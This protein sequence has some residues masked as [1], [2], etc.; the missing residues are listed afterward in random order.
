M[1]FRVSCPGTSR[2]YTIERRGDLREDDARATAFA[3]SPRRSRRS[4]RSRASSCSRPARATRRPSRRASRTSPSTCS[5]RARS[6]DRRR[7]RSRPRSTRSAAS[8]TRSRARSSPATT[9]AAARRHA[10][11]RSTSSPTCSS[12]R[13]STRRR[14]TK[15]KG[16]I[17]EEM[18]VYLDTP[19]R[20]VGNVYDRLL[21]ADQPLGW[22]ILGT[23]ETIEEATR[24]TFTSYLDTWYRPERMVVGI[25]G[26][27]GDGLTERLEE[28]LGWHRGPRDR[29]ARGR[30][31]PA[32]LLAG[33]AAHEGLGA[34][35]PHSRRARLP[36]R[37]SEPVRAPAARGRA[38]RRDVVAPLHRGAREARPRLLRA[39]GEHGVHRRG[40]LLLERGSRRRARGRGDHDD[41]RR[42]AEDRRRAR[43]RR[44]AREGARL[45]EGTLR[46][47]P[48]EPA[49]NDPVRA[50]ARGARGRDRRSR[51]ASAAARPGDGRGRPAS[52]IGRRRA[53]LLDEDKRLWHADPRAFHGARELGRLL[54]A[55]LAEHLCRPRSGRSHTT[56]AAEQPERAVPHSAT[57]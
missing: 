3:S 13:A 50:P 20:Y 23:R 54:R 41:P 29:P 15:E 25:G 48:R 42:D 11:P 17:L 43:S 35:A 21:Y 1:A 32:G 57:T 31:A 18:N 12:T 8:S 49:G 2:V 4:D 22:D 55:M 56:A 40:H 51:R 27:I 47:S 45:R 30:R 10:T 34:G 28:L 37:P 14:S 5:S 44:R 19:Q 39:R 33:P 16:V 6:G 52:R 53:A 26:R 36:D 7:A 38:R 9:S 46:A 24:E